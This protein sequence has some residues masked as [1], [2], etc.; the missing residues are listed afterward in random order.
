MRLIDADKLIERIKTSDDHLGNWDEMN[1]HDIKVA[2]TI[3][4]IPIDFI[5]A[6]AGTY[7]RL[8]HEEQD[9]E[10]R[11]AFVGGVT[12]LTTLLEVWDENKKNEL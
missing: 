8:H 11:N 3:E 10:V 12:G 4:A 1:I 5:K 2:E 7:A 6:L 9:I